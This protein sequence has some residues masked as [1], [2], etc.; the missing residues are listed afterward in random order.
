MAGVGPLV[1]GSAVGLLVGLPE[2]GLAVGALVAPNSVGESV[3]GLP[4]GAKVGLYVH[5]QSPGVVPGATT[6][7]ISLTRIRP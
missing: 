7:F 6:E 3:V 2:V 5:D 1:V 4:V